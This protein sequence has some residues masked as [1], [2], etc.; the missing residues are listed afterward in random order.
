MLIVRQDRKVVMN[1][2]NISCI[3]INRACPVDLIA[4][5]PRNL[6][7]GEKYPSSMSNNEDFHRFYLGTFHTAE[8]AQKILMELVVA[9]EKGAKVFYMPEYKVS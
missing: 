3:E 5:V 4:S 1:I 7:K 9:Y 8:K 6:V 2:D